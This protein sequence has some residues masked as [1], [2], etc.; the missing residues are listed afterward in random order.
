MLTVHSSSSLP[1]TEGNVPVSIVWY[2]A[3]VLVLEVQRV[4]I[5][6]VHDQPR[7]PHPHRR[8]VEVDLVIRGNLEL[9]RAN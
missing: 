8:A 3:L 4:D 1:A 7:V 2:L 6:R 5:E 9:V